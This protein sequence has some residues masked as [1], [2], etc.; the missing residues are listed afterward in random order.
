MLLKSLRE[1]SVSEK[2]FLFTGKSYNEAK[3]KEIAKQH[4]TIKLPKANKNNANFREDPHRQDHHAGR[5][6]LGQHR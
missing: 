1:C 4:K 5:G 6:A 3:A 2:K